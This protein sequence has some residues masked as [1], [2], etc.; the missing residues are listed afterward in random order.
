MDEAVKITVGI[1]TGFISLALISVIISRKSQT[2]Q[3]IQAFS[4]GLSNIVAAAVN[5]VN[6]ATTNANLSVPGFGGT[7]APQSG[8]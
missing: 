2:P 3:V 6:T 8:F 1:F 5:P 4:S 7:H